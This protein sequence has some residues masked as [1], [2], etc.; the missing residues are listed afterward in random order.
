MFSERFEFTMYV[1]SLKK[2]QY[3]RFLI[4]PNDTAYEIWKYMLLKA[5]LTVYLNGYTQPAIWK[6]CDQN[7]RKSNLLCAALQQCFQQNLKEQNKNRILNVK[8]VCWHQGSIFSL[9]NSVKLLTRHSNN[10][11]VSGNRLS[12]KVEYTAVTANSFST[13]LFLLYIFS[14][15]K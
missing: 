14:D 6:R 10:W 3:R 12:Q 13:W 8:V 1:P 11:R 4:T 7:S 5:A 2:F 15:F 9:L